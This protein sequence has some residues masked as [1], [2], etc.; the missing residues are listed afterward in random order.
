MGQSPGKGKEVE[1]VGGLSRRQVRREAPRTAGMALETLA[2]SQAQLPTRVTVA[3]ASAS[4]KQARKKQATLAKY[5][6][7]VPP[8]PPGVTVAG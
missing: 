2:H 4:K 5:N 8:G 1:R 7:Q 6:N 3:K